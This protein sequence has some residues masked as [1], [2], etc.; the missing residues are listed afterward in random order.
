MDLAASFAVNL[1]I[2]S[3]SLRSGVVRMESDQSVAP[4]RQLDYRHDL[5]SQ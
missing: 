2:I 3:A 5:L 4:I 1:P